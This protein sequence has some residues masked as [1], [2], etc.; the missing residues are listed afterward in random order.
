MRLTEIYKLIDGIA[1][2]ALSAEYCER[3]GAYDNSGIILDCGREIGKIFFTL[4]CSLS[5][6]TRAKES[7]ADLI[8]TH[9]PAIYAPL[10]SLSDGGEGKELLA[11]AR[12]GIS[13]LSAHLNLDCSGDGIDESLMKGLGGRRSLAVMHNLSLGGY[14]RVYEVEEAPF[15]DYQKQI[16]GVFHTARAVSYGDRSVKRVASFCGAGMDEESVSFALKNGA[17]TYISSDGKHHLVA[18]AIDGGMNV[19]LLTHYAAECY[20]F[21]R[22]YQK[23]KKSAGVPCEFF[24]DARLM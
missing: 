18:Q 23:I 2:F 6:V 19:V 17:D 11:C 21:E 7:G 4:D 14:G 22:F 20:G 24:A 15:A 8:V 5:A 13:V 12:A 3:Y 16:E 10:K 9:H 1:P